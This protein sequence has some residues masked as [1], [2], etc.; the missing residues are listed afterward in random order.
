[1][2]A[3]QL[4]QGEAEW[5]H[6]IM[7]PLESCESAADAAELADL[8]KESV[9]FVVQAYHSLCDYLLTE[10]QLLIADDESDLKDYLLS[11]MLR[12][13]KWLRWELNK[14]AARGLA[15]VRRKVQYGS[16]ESPTDCEKLVSVAG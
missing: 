8:Q 10:D 4:T 12:A 15:T 14:K 5:V 3:I 2:R 6:V 7:E 11:R 1:M 13:E 16:S 9:E